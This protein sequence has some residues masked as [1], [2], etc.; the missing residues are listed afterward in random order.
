M[1]KWGIRWTCFSRRKW[2]PCM[3]HHCKYPPRIIEWFW[4]YVCITIYMC[5]H[6]L[7]IFTCVDIYIRK[8]RYVH[9]RQN[10]TVLNHV[11]LL[12]LYYHSSHIILDNDTNANDLISVLPRFSATLYTKHSPTLISH[13]WWCPVQYQQPCTGFRFSWLRVQWSP[14]IPTLSNPRS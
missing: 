7:S 11:E 5:M 8:C 4:L 13:S 10:T 2:L 6:F 14:V 9:T 1:V 3:T 12:L